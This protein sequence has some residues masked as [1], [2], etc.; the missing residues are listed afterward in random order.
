MQARRVPRQ[1]SL[2][3]K[4]KPTRPCAASVQELLGR[5][6]ISGVPADRIIAGRCVA[7]KAAAGIM[8]TQRDEPVAQ[9]ALEEEQCP[10]P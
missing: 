1:K 8:T 6:R 10:V 5:V 9:H 3:I 2:F 7:P 4:R